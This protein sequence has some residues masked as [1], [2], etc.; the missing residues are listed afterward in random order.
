MK[1]IMEGKFYTYFDKIKLLRFH[2]IAINIF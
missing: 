2:I 1:F